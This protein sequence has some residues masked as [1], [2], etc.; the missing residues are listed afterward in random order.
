MFAVL[1]AMMIAAAFSTRLIAKLANAETP[2]PVVI[3][4]KPAA[5]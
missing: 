1:A 3:A 4:P 2:R 5:A